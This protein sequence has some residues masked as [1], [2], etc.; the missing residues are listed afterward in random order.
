VVKVL[1]SDPPDPDAHE[2]LLHWLIKTC[3]AT[4]EELEDLRDVDP[5]AL[6]AALVA[7]VDGKS[8][9]DIEREH[10]D[11]WSA[12]KP[13]HLETL[14]VWSLTGAFELIAALA[15]AAARGGPSSARAEPTPL[16][17]LRRRAVLLGP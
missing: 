6:K 10:A 5:D 8:G 12:V 17:R 11:A 14:L 13:A 7:W 1:R 2:R 16:R 9:A 15:D 3:V 4:L